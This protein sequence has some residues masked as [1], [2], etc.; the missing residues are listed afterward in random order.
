M[1][2]DQQRTTPQG[3]HDPQRPGNAVADF[4]VKSLP[5]LLTSSHSFAISAHGAH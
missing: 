5:K 3:R 2:P 4:A 1:D